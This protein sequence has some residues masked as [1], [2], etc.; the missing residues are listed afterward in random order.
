MM[1]VPLFYTAV[2]PMHDG[3]HSPHEGEAH[4]PPPPPPSV[5]RVIGRISA[6]ICTVLYLTSRL[7]QIWVNL[8]R[9]SVEGLSILLF[10][11]AFTGN[12]LYTIS[13]LINPKSSDPSTARD[14]LAESTPFLLGSGG[15]LIFDLIIVSQWIAWRG[16][17]PEPIAYIQRQMRRRSASVST[18]TSA[19]RSRSATPTVRS[20]T[21]EHRR[22]M[23]QSL[24]FEPNEIAHPL[25]NADGQAT[26]P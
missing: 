8:S 2:E 22:R 17:R 26:P 16:N 10:L 4:P 15:T 7:P 1:H 13:I 24:F 25:T 5:E 11:S 18:H 9:R 12:L 3:T 6:W 21:V 19:G 23:T 20:P 14:Y